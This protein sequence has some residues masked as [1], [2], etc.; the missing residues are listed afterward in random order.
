MQTSASPRLQSSRQLANDRILNAEI[1][2]LL[3]FF[4]SHG[5]RKPRIEGDRMPVRPS[6]RCALA[7][8]CL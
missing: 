5:D 3:R 2:D 7:R 6:P 4:L 8:A 1:I